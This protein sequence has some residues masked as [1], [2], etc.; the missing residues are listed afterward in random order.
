MLIYMHNLVSMQ[1]QNM[2]AILSTKWAYHKVFNDNVILVT[3]MCFILQT[4]GAASDAGCTAA[5]NT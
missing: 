4:C 2:N 5:R 1:L 3:Q